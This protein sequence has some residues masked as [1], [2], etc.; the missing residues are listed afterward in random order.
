MT[1]SAMMLWWCS[2]VAAMCAVA[3][4]RTVVTTVAVPYLRLVRQ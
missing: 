3:P 4:A 1:A 2:Y